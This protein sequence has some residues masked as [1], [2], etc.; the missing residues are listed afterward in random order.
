MG[1]DNFSYADQLLNINRLCPEVFRHRLFLLSDSICTCF[2]PF[3]YF[4]GAFHTA[5]RGLSQFENNS[6]CATKDAQL[7][8]FRFE[9]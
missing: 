9:R 2:V 7:F 6:K 1:L 8:N 5:L 4:V 3:F